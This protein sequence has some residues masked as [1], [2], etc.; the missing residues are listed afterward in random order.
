[1]QYLSETNSGVHERSAALN[2]N[3][4]R[5]SALNA[6]ARRDSA[7]NANARRD[8][9]LNANAQREAALNANSQCEA[10]LNANAQRE[11]T[12]SANAQREA[13]LNANRQYETP[14]NAE[15]R[16]YRPQRAPALMYATW[17]YQANLPGW[18]EPGG[19]GNQPSISQSR[20]SAGTSTLQHSPNVDIG[21]TVRQWKLQFSDAEGNNIEEFIERLSECRALAPYI[22]DEDLLNAMTEL[23][24]GVA[25]HWCRQERQKWQSWQ[26]FCEEARRCYGVD[27]RFQR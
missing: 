21:R 9:A 1:M 2:A 10:A 15:A 26:D 19:R 27:N 23:M 4:R 22:T 18:H 13:A 24:S 6:N 17:Q 12:L 8:S 20:Y 11:A 25:C 14:L 5:D 3:A 7:L 16:L